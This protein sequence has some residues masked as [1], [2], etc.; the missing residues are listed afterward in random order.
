MG[1]RPNT[2]D[3]FWKFIEFFDDCWL[4]TG[5]VSRAGYGRFFLGGKDNKAHRI[6]YVIHHGEIPEGQ[7]VCHHCDNPLCVNPDH[8][9]LGVPADNSA[10]VVSKRRQ[11]YGE[12]H[13]NSKLS[14]QQVCQLR[15][16]HDA[17]ISKTELAHMYDVS[18]QTIHRIISKKNWKYA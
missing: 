16:Q 2:I 15:K 18:Y 8:L 9:F 6:S 14:S 1:Q 5:T 12:K 7:F 10:D 11:A 4:W 13:W 3:D 17:N